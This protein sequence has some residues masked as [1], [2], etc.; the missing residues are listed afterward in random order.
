MES[1]VISSRQSSNGHENRRRYQWVRGKKNE[2]SQEMFHG[3]CGSPDAC[4]HKSF[5]GYI[6]APT[7][8]LLSQ[9]E[10]LHRLHLGHCLLTLLPTFSW[11]RLSIGP[12]HLTC[13]LCPGSHSTLPQN[14]SPTFRCIFLTWLWLY[15]STIHMWHLWA[16]PASTHRLSE[17]SSLIWSI[18]FQFSES[19]LMNH[20]LL[21]IHWNLYL[22]TKP[23]CTLILTWSKTLVTSHILT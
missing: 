21:F 7:N 19:S 11:L 12:S 17:P 18:L 23:V 13:R 20:F 10:L 16:S 1:G 14:I 4:Y 15:P 22:D 9:Q 8:S 3:V 2:E 6:C 5:A